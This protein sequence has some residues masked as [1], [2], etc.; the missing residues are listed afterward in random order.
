VH[1]GVSGD[2]DLVAVHEVA[3]AVVHR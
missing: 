3:D 1:D 2:D